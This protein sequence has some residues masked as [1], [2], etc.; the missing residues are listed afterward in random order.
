MAPGHP[1]HFPVNDLNA[2]RVPPGKIDS[3]LKA[4]AVQ[5]V[6]SD[7]HFNARITFKKLLG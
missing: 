6:Q 1:A 2:L 7:T 5:L 3:P 4:E